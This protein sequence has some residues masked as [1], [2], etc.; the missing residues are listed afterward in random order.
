MRIKKFL[1]TAQL[2]IFFAYHA[3][4]FVASAQAGNWERLH[5]SHG[6]QVDELWQENKDLPA[7]RGQTIIESDVWAILAILQDTSR[8]HEWVHRCMVS[9]QLERQ[10]LTSYVIYNRTD[11]T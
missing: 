11:A 4:A 8:S 3:P 10:G 1:L 5:S 9:R 7:F 6:I 2:F